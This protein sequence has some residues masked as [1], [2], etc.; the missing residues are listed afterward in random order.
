MENKYGNVVI[1]YK[2]LFDD[3]KEMMDNLKNIGI[4]VSR[5]DRLIDKIDKEVK[6][7]LVVG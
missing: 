1:D 4:D 6:M 2:A 5:F 3:V 7:I